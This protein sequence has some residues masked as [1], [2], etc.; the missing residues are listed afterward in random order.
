MLR[1]QPP[2]ATKSIEIV[3]S[4]WEPYVTTQSEKG[5]PVGEMVAAVLERSGYRSHVVFASW[6][7]G[8]AKVSDGNAFAVFP[9]VKS[10]D[11]KDN[12][13][14]S[15]PLVGFTYV[16]FHRKDKS[17]SEQVL[18]GDLHDA[19]VG[20]IE[21]YDYWD[22][23]E[24]S[25]ANFQSFPT[26]L[27]GFEALQRGEIDFLAESELVGA[28][29][30]EGEN[31]RGDSSDF[32]TVPRLAPAHSSQDYVYFV[33][34]KGKDSARVIESFNRAL[35]EYK[36]TVQYEEMHK[37]LDRKIER[38]RLA[39]DKLVEVKDL[40]GRV[41]GEVPS[42]AQLRVLAW[43]TEYR[44]GNQVRV[45]LLEGP[46]VGRVGAVNLENVVIIGD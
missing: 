8:L 1:L 15:D 34:K 22:A 45:K 38:A 36:T 17:I 6:E 14:Y 11:R 4:D 10:Q 44:R 29:T 32:G 9:M 20:K 5:G 2:K 31:F 33:M 19:R 39:G 43:P 25:G 16:L 26:T 46:L 35:A 21:G 13:E 7:N 37:S 30:L 42:G 28:A 3:T 27:A 41:M 23:L 40:S 24:N 18:N 12:F